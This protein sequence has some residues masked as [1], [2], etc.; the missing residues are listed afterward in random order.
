MCSKPS[1]SPHLKFA[2]L[3]VYYA[4]ADLATGACDGDTSNPGGGEPQ[5]EI[6]GY[7]SLGVP[8]SVGHITKRAK[9]RRASDKRGGGKGGRPN[10]EAHARSIVLLKELY[11]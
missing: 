4:C 11:S 7:S 5:V 10:C 1:P 9:R 8:W 3:F 2:Y 6:F